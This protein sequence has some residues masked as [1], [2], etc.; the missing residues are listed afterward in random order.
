MVADGSDLPATFSMMLRDQCRSQASSKATVGVVMGGAVRTILLRL[1]KFSRMPPKDFK[2][3][4]NGTGKHQSTTSRAVLV[5]APPNTLVTVAG[6]T[7]LIGEDKQLSLLDAI[8][9]L[10][11]KRQ[12]INAM[13]Y[14]PVNFLLAY[15]A[16]DAAFQWQWMSADGKQVRFEGF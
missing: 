1:S 5:H 7:M 2:V 14:G 10:R 6:C 11:A 15:A 16:G 8:K 13:H 4:F 9:D 3:H 12:P